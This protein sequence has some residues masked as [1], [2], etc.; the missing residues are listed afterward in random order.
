MLILFEYLKKTLPNI[1]CIEPL[2]LLLSGD[3]W[4]MLA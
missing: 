2:E 1:S 4:N 3:L